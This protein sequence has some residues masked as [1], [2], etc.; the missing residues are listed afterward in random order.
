MKRAR[1]FTYCVEKSVR[2]KRNPNTVIAET[3]CNISDA[4]HAAKPPTSLFYITC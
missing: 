1:V 2:S 4:G 3:L